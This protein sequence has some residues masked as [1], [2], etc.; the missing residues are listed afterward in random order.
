MIIKQT[1]QTQVLGQVDS[2]DISLDGQTFKTYVI[3]LIITFLSFFQKNG[4]GKNERKVIIKYMFNYDSQF[5]ADIS[6]KHMSLKN[7]IS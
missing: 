5:S 7:K 4:F 1:L 3:Y 2:F 6:S